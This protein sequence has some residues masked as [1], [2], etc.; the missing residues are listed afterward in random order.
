MFPIKI[1]HGWRNGHDH[2]LV[3]IFIN[4]LVFRKSHSSSARPYG[5]KAVPTKGVQT[6]RPYLRNQ[7]LGLRVCQTDCGGA[8]RNSEAFSSA[9]VSLRN[10]PVPDSTPARYLIFSRL[11]W[12]GKN[13]MW[14]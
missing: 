4:T 5:L 11:R 6:L 3:L 13:S 8:A 7:A 10:K 2:S 1:F 9:S 12:I 14:K